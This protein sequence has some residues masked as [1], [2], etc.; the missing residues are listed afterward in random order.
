MEREHNGCGKKSDGAQQIGS[1]Y[2]HN[3]LGN[4]GGG[5][6]GESIGAWN[7]S[8]GSGNDRPA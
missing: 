1:N 5:I 4:E 7:E 3:E 2:T 6:A 8:N